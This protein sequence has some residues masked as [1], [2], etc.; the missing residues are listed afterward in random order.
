VHVPDHLK[1]SRELAFRAVRWQTAA[2]LLSGLAG[3]AVTGADA[4]LAASI[5]GFSLV[6]GNAAMAQMSLGGGIQPPRGAFARLLIGAILKWLLVVG[7]WVGAMAVLKKAPLAALL[8]LLATMAV[9]P[10]AIIFGAKVKR[11][12]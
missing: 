7:V 6:L 12:R 2:A 9:H 1:T 4:G 8:G 3:W 5:G 10:I 11:E